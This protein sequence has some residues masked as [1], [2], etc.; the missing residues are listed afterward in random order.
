[1]FQNLPDTQIA[2]SALELLKKNEPERN[3]QEFPGVPLF[4]GQSDQGVLTVEANGD[5]KVPFFFNQ[6]DLQA[7]LDRAQADN[8]EVTS[9]TQIQVTTLAQVLDSM[10]NPSAEANVQ[11]I[12][13]VPS[14]SALEYIRSL[15]QD[16]QQGT[17][18]TPAQ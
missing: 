4:Y 16:Q 15:P 12:E 2:T 5:S 9:K 17:I 10:M 11:K 7:A 8:P 18:E 13:F 1:V 14:R 6:A 3:L